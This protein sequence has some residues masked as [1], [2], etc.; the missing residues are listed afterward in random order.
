MPAT[1]NIPHGMTLEQVLGYG[2]Q[3]LEFSVA[4]AERLYQ[5]NDVVTIRRACEF[6]E[7]QWT[8]DRIIQ[9]YGAGALSRILAAIA[10]AAS[11]HKVPMGS[12]V[13]AKAGALGLDI[14]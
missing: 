6:I 8:C 2:D 13:R 5:Q 14:Y 4:A 1:L 3:P 9:Q 12:R 11:I 7:P 10:K